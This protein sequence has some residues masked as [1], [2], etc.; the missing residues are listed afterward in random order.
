MSLAAGLFP[1]SG[2]FCSQTAL[3]DDR[4]GFAFFVTSGASISSL[5]DIGS[6][7]DTDFLRTR[8]IS[9]TPSP[10]AIDS[11][12]NGRRPF[13]NLDKIRLMSI[14]LKGLH[15][16]PDDVEPVEIHHEY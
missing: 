3:T 2:V 4:A 9:A 12:M 7:G 16:F 15:A 10:K 11:N 8:L 14:S 6:N 5:T 13:V 1:Q